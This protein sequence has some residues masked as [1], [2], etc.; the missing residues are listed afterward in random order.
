MVLLFLRRI[1]ALF[2]NSQSFPLKNN[3]SIHCLSGK[4]K[5]EA[6]INYPKIMAL[7]IKLLSY[8]YRDLQIWVHNIL[9]I[10][11]KIILIIKNNKNLLLADID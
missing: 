5:G 1:L 7:I 8:N 3:K 6:K 9:K 10:F 4:K 2:I 11:R